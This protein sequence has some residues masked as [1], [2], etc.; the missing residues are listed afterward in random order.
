MKYGVGQPVRRKED[1]RLVT[2]RGQYLD[3]LH[4][5]GLVH[6]Y[7][8]RSPHS[9]AF[10]RGVDIAA[11]RVMPGVIGI[12]APEDVDWT[13]YLPVRV[14][15]KNRDGSDLQ[16]SPKRLLPDD[17]VRFAGEA[18]AMVV[19]ETAAQ[20]KDAAEAVIVEYDPL[21]ASVRPQSAAAAPPV[22][23]HAPGNLA[24][25]WTDGN[26]A[27]CNEAFARAAWKVKIDVVQNRIVPAPMEPRGGVGIYDPQ[28]DMFTLHTPTQGSA[29]V[30]D[31]VAHVLNLRTDQVRLITPD[32]GGGFGMK[33]SLVVELALILI[34]AKLY[35]RP[36]RWSGERME[37][38]LADAHGRDVQMTG[39]MA[40]DKDGHILAMRLNSS[41]NLGA[42]MT[43]VGPMIPALGLR[44]MGGVY[45]VP[46]VHVRVKGYFTNTTTVSSYRGA[47]RPEAIYITERLMD[48]AA[49]ALNLDRLEIRRRNL[50]APD[51]LPYRNWRGLSIDSGD[52]AANLDLAAR[53]AEWETFDRRRRESDSRGKKRGRGV[54]YYFE[55]SGGPPVSEPVVIRFTPDGK[56]ELVVA[57]QTNGQGHDT[58]FAQLVCEQLGVPFDSVVVKQ[59]DTA[60]GL[61]GGG[62]VGSRSLQTAGSALT[63]AIDRVI[64]KGKAAARLV[65]QAENS[66]VNFKRDET[67][68]RF[69]VAG[70]K[71]CISLPELASA[72]R[73]D[74][75]PGFESGL[76]ESASFDSPPT[77]PNGCHICE[78]EV[79]PGTGAVEIC[80][81][82]VIDDVGRV[83]NPLIVDGQIH[84]GIA[85]GLGQ[86]LME[87]CRYDPDS[88][89]LSTAS[90][91]DYVL[92]RADQMP[93]LDIHYNE[94]LCKTNPLGVKG[95]GEAGTI[96]CLPAIIGAISDALGVAHID[97]PATPEKIWRVLN[98]KREART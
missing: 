57:T 22:W 21:E 83:I 24:F 70:T 7:F 69:E 36:V 66:G 29:G 55:A 78:V 68:G 13:G 93:A 76:D 27:G 47:G 77:F 3:D 56:V 82:V 60:D 62:T 11:A 67:G 48:Q 23:E 15:F 17:K 71:R 5:H 2:G 53:T 10:I 26:E 14:P 35:R 81:Y 16:Q 39:E 58:V 28:D 59:G 9:H 37:S 54:S 65:L 30:R 50:V 46:A 38:F 61:S 34:A 85:Q 6:A 87:D 41:A 90:F 97:M 52:F 12:L 84:G 44:V 40:L 98:E 32:V 86:A 43:H 1:I 63:R 88:G 31:K 19:A 96:G 33:N 49:A 42:Y 8:V 80:R 18:V 64:E 94:V 95:A 72:L 75:L 20:A 79:D 92:P 51:E 91:A 73:E 74:R 45:R 25:D 89:Q 4:F